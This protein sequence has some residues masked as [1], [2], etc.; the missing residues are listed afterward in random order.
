[1]IS[2]R[3]GTGTVTVANS[4]ASLLQI[5]LA[6]TDGVDEIEFDSLR[7]PANRREKSLSGKCLCKSR[8][9]RRAGEASE[10]RI[11]VRS[12]AVGDGAERERLVGM[13]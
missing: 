4:L 11:A 12:T 5:C 3:G 1:M 9:N 8:E 7:A 13:Q 6:M 2:V 10:R